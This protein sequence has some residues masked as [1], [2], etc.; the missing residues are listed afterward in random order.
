MAQSFKT[1]IEFGLVYIPITLYAC[2]KNNDIGFNMIHKKTGQRIKYKK[3]CENCPVNISNDDIV[4]GYEY[5]KGKYVTLT[6]AEIE[7]V[8]SPKDKAIAISTFVDLNEIDPIYY[9]KSYYASPIGADKAFVM[10]TQA[11]EKENKV[12]IAKTVLGTKEQVVALRTINGSLVVSTMHFYDEIQANPAKV[13]DVKVLKEELALACNLIKNMS[14]PF[15][16]EEYKNEYRAKLLKA[17]NAKIE[18]KEIKTSTKKMPHN[19]INLMDALKKSVAASSK[20]E[21]EGGKKSRA[22]A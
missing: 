19:V 12:G 21:K 7:K 15:K 1:A 10:L 18:G 11:L 2:V 22:K 17:I 4:K 6:D 5:E 20:T 8:K 16:A 9:E 14:G 3:I 13:K